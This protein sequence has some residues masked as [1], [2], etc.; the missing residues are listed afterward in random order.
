MFLDKLPAAGVYSF[1]NPGTECC[2]QIAVEL[3]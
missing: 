1:L 2:R 3:K